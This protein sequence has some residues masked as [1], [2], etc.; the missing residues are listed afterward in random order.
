MFYVLCLYKMTV[1]TSYL[2][3]IIYI[4][5][6]DPCDKRAKPAKPWKLSL[7]AIYF[8]YDNLKI[9]VCVTVSLFA[10]FEN[11]IVNVALEPN[12]YTVDNCWALEQQCCL[13]WRSFYSFS[14]KMTNNIQHWT[15]IGHKQP[16]SSDIRKWWTE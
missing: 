7:K 6:W 12:I 9:R 5:T 1:F 15:H 11:N 13:L 3:S 4:S 8:W 2:L 14:M 16:F 10:L